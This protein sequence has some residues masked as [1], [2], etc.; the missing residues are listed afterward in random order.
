MKRLLHAL[1][2]FLTCLQ[3]CGGPQGF[4]QCVAWAG[5]LASYSSGRTA[6]EAVEMTFDG[7]HPC[8]LCLAIQESR[9]KETECPVDNNPRGK[10]F[11]LLKDLPLLTAGLDFSR[12]LECEP[13]SVPDGPALLAGIDD[14]SPAVPPPRV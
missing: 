6:A 4:M 10:L 14:A 8:A 12:R 7:E 11:K 9:E 2:V 1:L 5:M 13:V 3:L